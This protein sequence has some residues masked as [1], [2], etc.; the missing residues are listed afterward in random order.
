MTALGEQQASS[1][2]QAYPNL[3]SSSDVILT[4]PLRRTI[5]TTLVGF[6]LL[7]DQGV[8]LELWPDLCVCCLLLRT[9]GVGSHSDEK[10]PVRPGPL[11]FPNVRSSGK[12]RKPIRVT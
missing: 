5:Q 3:Y 4:S 9:G 2:P 10:M 11:H 8:P 1:L 7:R 6:P 12:K